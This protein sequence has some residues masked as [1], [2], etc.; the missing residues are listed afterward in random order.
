MESGVLD[1]CCF[2]ADLLAIIALIYVV[3][4]NILLTQDDFYAGGALKK[5]LSKIKG[6]RDEWVHRS[7]S[8][9]STHTSE[10]ESTGLCITR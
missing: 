6:Q 1:Y 2:S 9:E 5:L 8:S 3:L 7:A 10:H 4:T